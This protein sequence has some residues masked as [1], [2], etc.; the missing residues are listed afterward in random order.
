MA[1]GRGSHRSTLEFGAAVVIT[2]SL[3]HDSF[4]PA[5]VMQLECA[6]QLGSRVD[7]A[8]RGHTRGG[9]GW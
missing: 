9:G 2:T 4:R 3:A 8:F 7:A 1:A 5:E 6:L